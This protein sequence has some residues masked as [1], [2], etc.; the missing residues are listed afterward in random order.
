MNYREIKLLKQNNKSTVSLVQEQGGE[1]LFVRKRL[2]GRHP[3]YQELQGVT[4]PGLPRLYEV[5]LDDE[6]TTVI[7]E[8]IEG[9]TPGNRELSKKQFLS[10]VK[11]LCSV[12]EFLHEKGIIHRD[13]KPS[14]IIFA[15]DGHIR[16]IDF[17]AARMCL[18]Q[19]RS[20]SR[21]PY[22]LAPEDMRRRNSMGS[23]R[24]MNGRISMRLALPLDRFWGMMSVTHIIKNSSQMHQS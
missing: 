12:L 20:R 7:E 15:K 3:V 9:E 14:N 2:R 8:Y 10:I 17:D 1:K 24:P 18:R 22:C 23:P 13:I 16:L 11:E 6:F 19:R 21:T 4:H 5:V